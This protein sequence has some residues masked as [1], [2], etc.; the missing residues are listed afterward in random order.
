MAQLVNEHITLDQHDDELVARPRRRQDQV[1]RLSRADRRLPRAGRRQ[2]GQHSGRA[3]GRTEDG[4][5]VAQRIPH[6]R[7][8][9]RE[10]GRSIEGKVGESLR[11]S[12]ADL[13]LSRELATIR[14]DVELPVGP[15]NCVAA[16]PTIAKLREIYARLELRSLLKIARRCAGVAPPLRSPRG[17]T[18]RRSQAIAWA[19]A[20]SEHGH[21]SAGRRLP[22]RRRKLGARAPLRDWS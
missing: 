15:E 4:R 22:A 20:R 13:A 21:R 10:P 18:R 16:S 9:D 5:E 8:P 1:R 17:S 6:A 2:L 14:C 7:Q 11:A 19:S 3:E 12:M